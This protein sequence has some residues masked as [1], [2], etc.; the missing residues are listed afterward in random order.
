M[1]QI[2]RAAQLM[3]K[4]CAANRKKLR[5]FLVK[6]AQKLSKTCARFVRFL[7]RSFTRV[8]ARLK[9]TTT[10]FINWQFTTGVIKNKS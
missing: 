6:P 3:I 5:N 4:T 10:S 8:K 7:R 9:N 1:K 2:K